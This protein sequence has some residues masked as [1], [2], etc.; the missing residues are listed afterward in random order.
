[1][2]E[3]NIDEAKLVALVRA[4]DRAAFCRLV[5]PW[6][7]AVFSAAKAILNDTAEAE[8]VAHDA[9]LSALESFHGFRGHQQFGTWLV[10]ITVDQARERLGKRDGL[11]DHSSGQI[12]TDG[13]GDYFPRDLRNWRKIPAEA[14]QQKELSEG[15]RWAFT[16]LPQKCREVFAL[17]DIEQLNTYEAAEALGLTPALVRTRLLRA[18]LQMRDALTQG[19]R[20]T[21]AH[22]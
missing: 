18:R 19:I 3:K 21:V 22:S 20:H 1:M 7:Q 11:G 4:G 2:T 15:L 17:R 8:E 14:L 13:E 12:G 16:S 10:R 9:I 5:Q 6:E